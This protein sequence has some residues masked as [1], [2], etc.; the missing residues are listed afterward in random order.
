MKFLL[1]FVLCSIFI[2]ADDTKE[3]QNSQNSSDEPFLIKDQSGLTPDEIRQRAQD[4]KE[5]SKKVSIDKVVE[6]VDKSGNIDISDIQQPWEELSPTPK[7]YD[8]IQTKSGEW[9]KGEI[10]AMYDDKLEFD[11]DEIGVHTFKFKDINQIKSYHI[12]DIN[13]EGVATIPGIIRYK[14]EKMVIIQGEDTYTF[15]KNQIVSLALSGKK[16]RNYWSGKFTLSIDIR[17]GNKE[18]FDYT[19]KANILRRTA[20]TRLLFDYLGRLSNVGGTQTVNDHRLNEKYDIY[21]TRYFFWTPLFSE[22]YTDKFQNIDA[23]YTAGI[24]V[25]YTII[26]TPKMDWDVSGGPAVIHIKY[27][28]VASG[29]DRS[30]TSFAG[31]LSTRL[32]Y[33][34]SK[35]TDLKFQYKMTLSDKTSG[36][37]KHHMLVTL[38]NELLEWLDFDVTAIWDYTLSPKIA[39]DGTVPFK[40][41]YQLLVGLGLEF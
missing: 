23:Q 25:G 31:E 9:F 5:E 38:E 26:D 16:E 2:F 7:K 21:I 14:D 35:Y 6:S 34:I 36:Q 19:A 29:A 32:E 10:K 8:W 18:Q 15:D 39:E 41:D 20:T 17:S 30:S 12:I 37:Y 13:I 33:D 11:S 1:L 28:T 40:D 24:G 4:E 27:A 3:S 22:Y